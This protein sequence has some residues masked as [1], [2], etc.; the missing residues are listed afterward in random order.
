MKEEK[1]RSHERSQEQIV[2]HL[3]YKFKGKEKEHPVTELNGKMKCPIC[4]AL[5][6][7]I[8]LHFDR[9]VKCSAEIYHLDFK[10][11]F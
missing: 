9:N 6:K 7:N 1:H 11:N 8:K 5:V 2:K 10:T 4:S 3:C